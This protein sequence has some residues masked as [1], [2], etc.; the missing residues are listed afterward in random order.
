MT[1]LQSVPDIAHEG[2]LNRSRSRDPHRWFHRRRGSTTLAVGCVLLLGACERPPA[3]RTP[4]RGTESP[5]AAGPALSR[6]NAAPVTPESADSAAA[7]RGTESPGA[8]GPVNA[9]PAAPES[10]DAAAATL[11]IEV[12][13]D[14]TSKGADAQCVVT[15]APRRLRLRVRASCPGGPRVWVTLKAADEVES[16]WT[17]GGPRKYSPEGDLIQGKWSDVFVPIPASK[18][19]NCPVSHQNTFINPPST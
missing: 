8:A 12:V 19:W 14:R 3:S 2:W 10:A 9:T 4:T 7:T 6:A 15:P 5:G 17:D 18:P 1:P 16:A 11:D 13:V